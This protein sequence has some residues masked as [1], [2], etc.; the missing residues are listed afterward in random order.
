MAS[1]QYFYRV[2]FRGCF[3]TNYEGN[4]IIIHQTEYTDRADWDLVDWISCG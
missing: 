3:D 2:C 4:G 1:F